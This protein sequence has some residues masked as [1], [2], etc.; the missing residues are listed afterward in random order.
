MEEILKVVS[1]IKNDI[2]GL[3]NEG[4]KEVQTEKIVN[5]DG[6]SS[7]GFL[8]S[9]SSV[10]KGVIHH[11]D[12]AQVVNSDDILKKLDDPVPVVN[13]GRVLQKDQQTLTGSIASKGPTKLLLI[14]SPLESP[15]KGTL[16]YVSEDADMAALCVLGTLE[17]HANISTSYFP[18]DREN[19]KHI[20]IG[21]DVLGEEPKPLL[22]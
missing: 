1:V 13:S 17:G 5:S 22:H 12:A 8:K 7:K 18:N 3:D 9:V 2:L 21:G 15:Q 10:K 11:K 20:A 16:K 19:N 14:M 4:E 6:C